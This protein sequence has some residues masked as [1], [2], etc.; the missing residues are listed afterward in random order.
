[1]LCGHQTA[2]HTFNFV[3]G[4]PWDN[5]RVSRPLLVL[6]GWGAYDRPIDCDYPR[7]G[8]VQ[9]EAVAAAAAAE[10]A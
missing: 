9:P 8:R 7:H 3:D 10:H 5:N 2:S 1:M 4:G 6:A